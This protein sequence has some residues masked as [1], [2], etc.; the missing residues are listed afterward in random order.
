MIETSLKNIEEFMKKEVI[1]W[2]HM[3]FVNQ[4]ESPYSVEIKNGN[5]TW[6][7][8]TREDKKPE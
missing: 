6:N 8:S 4:P 5:F 7:C 1:N 2:S 3:K